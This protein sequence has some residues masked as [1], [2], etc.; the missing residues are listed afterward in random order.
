MR[1][2]TDE[3]DWLS[4]AVI[5]HT[6]QFDPEPDRTTQHTES[7]RSKEQHKQHDINGKES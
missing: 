1:R 3:F 6:E 7:R 2:V 5:E 4:R